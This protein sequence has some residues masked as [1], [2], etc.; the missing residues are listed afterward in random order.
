[1]NVNRRASPAKSPGKW[2][3]GE[4]LKLYLDRELRVLLEYT[5]KGGKTVCFLKAMSLFNA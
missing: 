4:R 2:E 5:G 1:M 3:N